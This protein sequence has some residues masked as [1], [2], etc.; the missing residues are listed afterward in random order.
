MA[1]KSFSQPLSLALA[2][3]GAAGAA[4]ALTP[5]TFGTNWL[6]EAEHGGF[7]Q[8]VADGTYKQCGLDVKIIPGGPQVNNRAQMLAGKEDFIMAGNM[9]EEFNAA[10]EGVPVMA[11]AAIFQKEP[12]VIL[13][14]PGKGKTLADLKNMKIQVSDQGYTSF[15]QWMVKTMGFKDSNREVYTFNP[16]PFI[17][18]PNLAMQGY[19]SSEPRMVEQEG[20][21][22]PDIYL[23]AD[24]GWSTYSTL[25]ET[26]AATVKSKPE[27]VKCFVDGSILGWYNYLYHDNSKANA[28]IKKDNPDMT[29]AQLA[30]AIDQMKAKGIADSGDTLKLGIGAM[31]DA[32]WKTFY[33]EM[34]AAQVVKPNIDYKSVYTTAFV[35]KG[36][37]LDLRPKN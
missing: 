2:L 23:I 5:V 21:F 30:F 32:R 18:N 37:G 31:T 25:I 6:A 16:G 12:Q 19:L 28:L 1:L 24:Y 29:D 34:V 9:L 20:H 14:H 22:K 36:L 33:D 13:T 7:Y 4:A 26:M 3:I 10:A 8:A 35:D 27:V 11:V 17:A 15:Y